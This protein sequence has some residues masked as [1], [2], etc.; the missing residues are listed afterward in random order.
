[1]LTYKQKQFIISLSNQG[2]SARHIAKLFKVSDSLIG[3]VVAKRR[4][5]AA[6][7]RL[8]GLTA[9]PAE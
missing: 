2:M 9:K 3:K 8:T 5:S 7:A 6:A 1:M 4:R